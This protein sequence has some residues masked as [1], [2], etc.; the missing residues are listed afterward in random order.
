MPADATNWELA[1]PW[2][3]AFAPH[4]PLLLGIACWLALVQVSIAASQIILTLVLCTWSIFAAKGKLSVVS[5]PLAAPIAVYAGTSLAA[6]LVSFDPAVSLQASKKL[7]LLIVP[8]MLVSAIR[9]RDT[10]EVLVLVLVVMADVSALVGLWQYRFGA[11]GDLDHRIRG[12]MGHYMTY[13][14]LLMGVGTLAFALWLFR[15]SRYRAFLIGS[16]ALISVALALT[17]TRSAWI[18]AAGAGL[19]LVFLKDRR[20][21]LVAPLVAVAGALVAPGDVERRVSSFLRP[22]TSG[23]DR[24]YMLEAGAAMVANHPWLGVGA[25]MVAEVYPIYRA[26]DAPAR[27]NLHLHNNIMQIAAERGIPCALAWLWLMGAAM[28]FSV[29]GYRAHATQ[30]RARALCAG[31]MGV[32]VATFIAGMGEYNFGDSELQMLLL[33]VLAVP[34]MLNGQERDPAREA[35]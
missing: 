26:A 13:S 27:D 28:F 19:L 9:K 20:L 33:F 29:Q 2:T 10:V 7:F 25:N 1:P 23:Y 5:I 24:L 32:W 14:G 17:L 16:V 15:G 34:F 31:A 35:S 8:F 18:G 11:L 30:P 6:A 21:L 12:F 3:E 4:A 22:D